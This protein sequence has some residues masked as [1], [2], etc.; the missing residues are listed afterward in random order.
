[1]PNLFKAHPWHGVPIGEDCP[2][3][4]NVYVEIVPTDTVKYEVDKTTGHLFVD[5]PQ[6]YSNQCPTLYGFVPQTYCGSEV[7]Q[8][9]VEKL[10]R[11]GVLGDGD[12]LDIC[13]LTERPIQHGDVLIRAIPIGGFRMID[14]NEVDDK[15]IA[16][17]YQDGV[18]GSW[19]D[20]S[21][22]P[23]SIINRLQHYFLTYKDMP[24]EEKA[25]VE[26]AA[27]YNADEAK[28]IIT[29]SRRDYLQSFCG[30]VAS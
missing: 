20:I 4:V 24:G 30:G 12:A 8:Y 27:V 17:L 22:C 13:V 9:C 28:Q 2:H 14:G 3:V 21:D 7:G 18:Y 23:Q 25:V 6:K 29:L 15:I 5:R 16:V 26:I 10:N 19:R 11:P 1:M